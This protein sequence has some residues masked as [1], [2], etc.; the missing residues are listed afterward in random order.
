MWAQAS[1]V[2]LGIWLIFSPAILH[3]DSPPS[4]APTTIARA[5]APIVIVI[6]L[7]ALRD[8]TRIF[9][10]LLFLPALWLVLS[11]W[12]L[13]YPPGVPLANQELV[14]IAIAIL[15]SIPGP[16][17]K[18]TGGGWLSLLT[19]LAPDNPKLARLARDAEDALQ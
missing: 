17:T 3:F 15:A 4:N 9:R 11:P 14:G 12:F 13:H 6:G 10:W 16:I 18:R 5:I 1:N 7:L 19:A 8:V 2:I